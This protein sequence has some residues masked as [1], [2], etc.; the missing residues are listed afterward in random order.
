MGPRHRRESAGLEQPVG[1]Q[2]ALARYRGERLG[3][4]LFVLARHLLTPLER[5]ASQVPPTGAVLDVGCGHGLF[6]N[7]LALQSAQR[8]VLGV[9]PSPTKLAVARRSSAGLANV[10]Y[11]E[12]E[13][14]DI[15]E[16]EFG[17]ITI[18][19]VL[20]LLS[21]PEKLAL[22]RHCRDLIATDGLLLLK[23]NDTRPRW[24][25]AV[26]R[27]QE[28]AMTKLGLTMGGGL[29]FRSVAQNA[30][31]LRMAGFEPRLIDLSG[32][33]PYAHRL[34]IARPVAAPRPAGGGQP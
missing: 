3:I 28:F 15:R 29:H 7:L 2:A 12:G 22:L 4:R 1:V 19:D 24:K 18:L 33:Q 27:L 17:T 20:Y 16:R 13:V 34:F 6:A 10:R 8:Q 14:H 11:V 23:T 25:Y 9:D 5:I 31:L 32:W 26:T 30:A 21:D